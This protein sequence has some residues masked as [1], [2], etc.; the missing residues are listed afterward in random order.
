MRKDVFKYVQSC[1]ACQ[2]F[3]YDNAPKANP[4]Q[5]HTV[6]QPWHTIGIDIMGP[7]PPTFRQKRFLLVIVDYFTRWVELF[8]LR[9]TTATQI[10]NIIIDEIICRYGAP[11]YILSDNGPQF[12]SILFNEICKD[13]G[14]ARKFTANYH[15]QTNMTE[16]VNRTLK[17][18]IAIYTQNHPGLW[19]K[20][21]QKLAFAIRTSV[22][23]TT[24][25]T[26]AF[27]NF[28]RDPITP[29]DLIL[30]NPTSHIPPKTPEHKF[31]QQ[32]RSELIQTLRNTYQLVRE[33][34]LIQKIS[35]KNKYD[36]HT[37]QRQFYVGDLV[38]IQI[39]TPQ[40]GNKTISQKL[41]PKYQGPCRLIEQLSS[42]TFIA[43]R[44]SDNV[45]L[46]ATNVD[47]IKPYY[48]PQNEETSTSNTQSSPSPPTKR[49]YSL[50]NRQPL[51]TY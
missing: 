21:L 24:G 32:Y 16:R 20:E 15:P 31:L 11:K 13:L 29:L 41:R 50:R 26:P 42:S 14:I 9:Q 8:A 39:P 1:T 27:L 25:D 48:E 4:M 28:G 36:K 30:K 22:N 47:R 51:K 33:H 18:L 3:K 5:L 49:R 45:N 17:P 38:W 23:E 6:S 35:Q 43:T 40:I 7:F 34:S 37:I 12:I 10:A 46:G 2:Q 19:D 44:L